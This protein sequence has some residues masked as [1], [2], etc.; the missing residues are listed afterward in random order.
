M[1]RFKNFYLESNAPLYNGNDIWK[2]QR[3]TLLEASTRSI[4]IVEF[5]YLYSSVF[6]CEKL[7][8]VFIKNHFFLNL[9]IYVCL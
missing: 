4:F 7:I 3:R 6:S 9:F 8:H 1:T 5:L 2:E